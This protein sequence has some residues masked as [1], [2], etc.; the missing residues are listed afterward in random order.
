MVRQSVIYYNFNVDISFEY[1]H[2]LN[3][4]MYQISVGIEYRT[5]IRIEYWY[6]SNIGTYCLNRVSQTINIDISIN[7]DTFGISVNKYTYLRI[8]KP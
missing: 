6:L 2:V 3:I 5:S 7:I 1:R 4:S 8:T